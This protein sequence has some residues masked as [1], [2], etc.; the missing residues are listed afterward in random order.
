MNLLIS[1]LAVPGALI[2]LVEMDL[3]CPFQCNTM[4]GGYHLAH[5]DFVQGCPEGR[6]SVWLQLPQCWSLLVQT[7]NT[8]NAGLNT[9]QGRNLPS[10]QGWVSWQGRT[11]AKADESYCSAPA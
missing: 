7:P 6:D 1:V 5:R 11:E 10:L 4:E 8:A 9:G 2:L 3:H